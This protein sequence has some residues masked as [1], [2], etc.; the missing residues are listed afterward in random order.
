[1][2]ILKLNPLLFPKIKTKIF[3]S[4][5]LFEELKNPSTYVQ[6]FIIDSPL[7]LSQR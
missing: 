7:L 5:D 3:W 4:L 6:F 1:M 2:C